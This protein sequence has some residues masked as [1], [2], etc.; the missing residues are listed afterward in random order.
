MAN[1]RAE[2]FKVAY[3]EAYKSHTAGTLLTAALMERVLDHD[4]VCEV[5]YLIGDDPYKKTWMSHRR[6]RWGI[7]AYN[8][9]TL[10]GLFGLA[11]HLAGEVKR[12][13][14][15]TNQPTPVR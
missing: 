3:D 15:P 9:R 12:R 7:A 10:V 14:W 2:I 1:G 8:P 11:R 6:E 13:W 5:D 4:Q